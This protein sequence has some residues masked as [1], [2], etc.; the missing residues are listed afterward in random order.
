[1]APRQQGEWRG[2]PS[3]ERGHPRSEITPGQLG[4]EGRGKP[5]GREKSREWVIGLSQPTK[6]GS[7]GVGNIRGT[8]GVCSDWRRHGE[9]G[10]GHRGGWS[11]GRSQDTVFRASTKRRARSNSRGK[12]GTFPVGGITSGLGE[13]RSTTNQIFPNPCTSVCVCAKYLSSSSRFLINSRSG[14]AL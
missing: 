8:R 6:H 4:V 9:W 3:V 2:G 14:P 7:H 10:R 12:R 5:G 13:I 1:M 11:C